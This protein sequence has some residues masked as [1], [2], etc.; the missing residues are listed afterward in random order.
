MPVLKDLECS[1]CGN[2]T[3]HMI[4]GGASEVVARC[5]SPE[6]R[7][8]TVHRAICNGG[9]RGARWRYADW[10]V[11]A[12]RERFQVRGVEAYTTDADGNDTDAAGLSALAYDPA[13]W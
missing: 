4:D 9:C 12:I 8:M 1:R 7:K 5:A 6:C 13:D 11:D 2:V 3:E 10:T